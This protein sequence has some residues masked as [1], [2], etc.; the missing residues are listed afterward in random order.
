[1]MESENIIFKNSSSCMPTHTHSIESQPTEST[2]SLALRPLCY[3]ELMQ[4]CF[5]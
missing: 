3:G 2:E 1:M 4:S 5:C